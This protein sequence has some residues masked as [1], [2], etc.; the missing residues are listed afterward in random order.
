MGPLLIVLPCKR[1]YIELQ[2]LIYWN[3][4]LKLIKF[5]ENY[6]WYFSEILSYYIVACLLHAKTVE[7][8]KRPFLNN[9][10]TQQWNNGVVQHPS[11]Q[12]LGKHRSNDVT[13][14]Q[15]LA[16]TWLVFSVWSAL[17]K[18]RTVFSALSVSQ[19]Y[20]TSTLAGSPRIFSWVPRFHGDWTR[21]GKKTS[22]W[23]EMLVSV[24]RS[25]ARRRIV[26]TESPSACA[27]VNS[28]LCKSV[29]ML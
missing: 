26:K 22:L 11:R 2:R 24:L 5:T 20:K 28:K 23:F 29:I 1:F 15:R 21:N 10:H 19:L 18:S 27:R 9:T 14:Q 8:Q 7:P 6:Y 16:I 17:R 12:R 3:T 13:T 25:V 4:C